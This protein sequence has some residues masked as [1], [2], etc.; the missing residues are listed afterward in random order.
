MINGPAIAG[1]LALAL[2][3]DLRIASDKAMLGDVSGVAGALPDEGGAWLFPRAMG[4]DHAFK[5]VALNEKYD[6]HA[7]LKL[8]LVTE[9]V[10]ASELAD[11]TMAIARE[12]ALRAPVTVRLTKRMM[13]RSFEGSFE[14]S[15]QDAEMAVVMNNDTEDA[16]EGVAAFLEHRQPRFTGR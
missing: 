3:C 1:G 11:R 4:F 2:I 7:A 10:P 6:A 14:S 15:L 16:K 9:V 8:G 5:M 12:F 13:R